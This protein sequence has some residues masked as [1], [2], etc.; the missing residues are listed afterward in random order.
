[1]KQ[2]VEIFLFSK[3]Y[4]IEKDYEEKITKE[5]SAKVESHDFGNA[6]KTAKVRT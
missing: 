2:C 6:E 3:D 5:L 1:M 4:Q